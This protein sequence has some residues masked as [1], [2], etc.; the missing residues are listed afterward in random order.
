[1]KILRILLILSLLIPLHLGYSGIRVIPKEREPETLLHT[2]LVIGIYGAPVIM[3][4]EIND[5]F[6]VM[7]GGRGGFIFNHCFVIGGAGYGLTTPLDVH[8][9]SLP[10]YGDLY[11]GYGGFLLEFTL[12]PHRLLHLSA[13]ALI[14]G[15]SL[16][17]EE[18][19]YEWYDDGFFVLEPGIDMELN[20]TRW[21]RIGAGGTYRFV[22]GVDLFNLTDQDISGPSAEIILKFG[23]F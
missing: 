6:G 13:H 17:Y 10:G 23:R 1:M 12:A 4:T 15:G 7:L 21:L 9:P 18:D 8:Y 11:M 16:C 22:H 14:G 2:P 5:Q 3:F 19:Y 20:V